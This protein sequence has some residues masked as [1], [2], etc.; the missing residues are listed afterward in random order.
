LLTLDPNAPLAD[1][2]RDLGG[3]HFEHLVAAAYL[4]LGY[5]PFR[6]IVAT[7]QKQT[8]AEIDVLATMVTPLSEVRV[9][10]ECKGE[11][12]SFNDLRKFSSL[13]RILKDP[14]PKLVAYGDDD[15]RAEHLKFAGLLGIELHRKLDVRKLI[16]PILGGETAIRRG[17][18][19]LFNRYLAVFAL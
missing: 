5:F 19:S 3:A 14:I 6:N 9:A 18:A 4:H 13:D 10:V 2:I 12:P 16:L 7:V 15:L 17:R 1:Q 8:A 11:T